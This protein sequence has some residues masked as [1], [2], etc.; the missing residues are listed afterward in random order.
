MWRE[1]ESETN[2]YTKHK[3]I[4][5]DWNITFIL[6]QV[7]MYGRSQLLFAYMEQ[8]EAKNKT[9]NKYGYSYLQFYS[10]FIIKRQDQRCRTMVQGLAHHPNNA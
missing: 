4:Q 6:V 5:A 10:L 7:Y 3:E 9:G 1:G 8:K 2:L